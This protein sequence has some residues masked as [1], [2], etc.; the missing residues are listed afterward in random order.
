MIRDIR[1]FLTGYAV[2][3]LVWA[4]VDIVVWGAPR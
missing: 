3:T 4:V 2:G 1:L